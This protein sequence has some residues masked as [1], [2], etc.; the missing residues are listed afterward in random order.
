[1][2]S[3]IL[4]NRLSRHPGIISTITVLSVTNRMREREREILKCHC[5]GLITLLR[6]FVF[7]EMVI[8]I[9]YVAVTLLSVC[10]LAHLLESNKHFCLKASLS[11][12][13]FLSYW[14]SLENEKK[15]RYV[16]LTCAYVCR[17]ECTLLL[18]PQLW[19]LWWYCDESTVV[20]N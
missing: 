12:S 17:C 5:F 19:F 6:H 15:E 20:I 3:K 1:M 9:F 10:V 7:V 13:L 8:I 4:L 18:L 14:H 16:P 2:F 11:F